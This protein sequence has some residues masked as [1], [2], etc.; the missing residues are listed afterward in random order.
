MDG[1]AVH[2]RASHD[3]DRDCDASRDRLRQSPHSTILPRCAEQTDRVLEAAEGGFLR[4]GH[5]GDG[6]RE[7]AGPA[8][9]GGVWYARC[10]SCGA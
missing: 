5:C 3:M 10:H 6:R 8:D 9:C 2:A 7:R 4:G 1:A